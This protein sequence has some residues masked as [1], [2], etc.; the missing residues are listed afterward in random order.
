[1]V[2]FL[3]TAFAPISLAQVVNMEFKQ[4][5]L[6]DVFQILGQLGGYNVLVDPSVSGDV[7]FV[8]NDLPVE[9][10]LD[11]VTRTTGYRYQLMGNTLVVASESRLKTEFGTEDVSFVSVNHVEVADAQRL[12]TLMV[13]G[14]R[15]YVDADLSLVVLFGVKSDL[16]KA[17]Q[18]LAQYDRQ[19]GLRPAQTV[20]KESPVAADTKDEGDPLVS[21]SITPLYADSTQILD[22]VRSAFPHREFA[23]N[24]QV[25]TLTGL[26]TAEEWE[27]VRLIVHDFDY[28]GFVVK[29]VLSS[30]EQMIALVEYQ[31]TTTMLKT[32]E[33][34]HGWTVETITSNTVKFVQGSRSFTIGLGR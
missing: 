19:G 8:L 24:A 25:G 30:A 26:A 5:P 32:G 17:E 33:S 7:S 31:G 13:P 23:W 1:L 9:E 27:Q 11:L 6:V 2:L 16:E 28:P 18:V 29:G 22:A 4:A 14:V 21:G 34:L 12:V 20:P 15:S 10:A 3:T